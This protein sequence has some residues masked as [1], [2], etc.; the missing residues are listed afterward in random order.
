M[1]YYFTN[2]NTAIKLL[3]SNLFDRGKNSFIKYLIGR[4]NIKVN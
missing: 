2:D 1:L 3:I 4:L